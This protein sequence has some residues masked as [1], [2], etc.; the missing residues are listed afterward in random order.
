MKVLQPAVFT[1]AVSITASAYKG[2][3][4][5]ILPVTWACSYSMVS[6][7]HELK[8]FGPFTGTSTATRFMSGAGPVSKKEVT[9]RVI[10][11]LKSF[12]KVDKLKLNVEAK[13]I[14]TLGL[15]SLDHVEVLMAMEEEFDLEIPDKV[16]ESIQTP[17]DAIEY[18][19]SELNPEIE[20][21]NSTSH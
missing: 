20:G 3:S 7:P 18:I 9:D 4:L 17:K 5:R 8:S 1:R 2:Y 6:K 16:A 12:E 14:P 10:S 19:Y 11:I 15:D 21:E 13:F